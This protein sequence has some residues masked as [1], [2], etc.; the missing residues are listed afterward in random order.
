MNAIEVFDI[1]GRKIQSF[2]LNGATTMAKPFVFAEGIY[3]VKIK[4]ENGLIAS[5]KLINK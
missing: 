2:E 4:L 1:S 3:I 5:Q